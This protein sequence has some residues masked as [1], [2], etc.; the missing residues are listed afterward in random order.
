MEFYG[1]FCL[2]KPHGRSEHPHQQEQKSQ[3]TSE[4]AICYVEIRG[5]HTSIQSS[6]ITTH[7]EQLT[8][9][10]GKMDTVSNSFTSMWWNQSLRFK[11]YNQ[12]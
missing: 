10:C 12:L 3:T 6:V 11:G 8:Q 2:G 9:L 1:S 5:L 7:N 4:L